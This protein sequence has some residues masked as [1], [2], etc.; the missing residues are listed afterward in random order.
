MGRESLSKD[1][2]RA[3]GFTLLEALIVVSITATL[4]TLGIP[5]FRDFL[6]SRAVTAQIS[7]LAGSIRLA[8]TEAIKRGIPV[9]LCC[10]EN[11]QA[12]APTCTAGADW[13]SGWLMF[14]DRGVRGVFEANDLLIRVQQGYTNSGGV[15]RSGGG[16]IT[17]LPTGIAPGAAGNFLMRPKLSPTAPAYTTLSKRMCVSNMGSTRLIPGAAVCA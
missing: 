5:S 14:A 2:G 9:T 3:A 7:D 10:S 6:A 4:L 13:S 12:A 17:F 11:P 8:R 1:S 16:T 15:V